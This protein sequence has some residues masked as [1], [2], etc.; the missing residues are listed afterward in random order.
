LQ[1]EQTELTCE[2]TGAQDLVPHLSRIRIFPV[3]S[4][5][6]VEVLQSR[7]LGSGALE[8]DRAWALFDESGGY[9]NGKRYTSVHRLRSKFDISA[10]ALWLRDGEGSGQ[11]FNIDRETQALENRLEGFFGFRVAIRKNTAQGFPDDEESPGPTIISVATLR[12][13]GRWF[14][15]SVEEVRNRFRANLEIDGV[16]PFWED[17]LFRDPGSSVRF[18]IGNVIFDGINP[19]QRC[20]V[21][22]RDAHSGANDDTFVR[23]FAELRERTLPVW[24]TRT[25]FNHFYRV[26]INTRLNSLAFGDEIFVGDTVEILEPPATQ[27]A[28]DAIVVR[29]SAADFWTGELEIDAVRK[30][31]PNVK[32]FRLRDPTKGALPFEFRPG[33]FLSVAVGSGSGGMRRCYSIASAPATTGYCEITVKREGVVSGILHDAMVPG[34]RVTVS[35]PMGHFMIADDEAS[36]L[37]MIAGGVG[38]TPLMSKLRHLAQRRWPGQIDLF[39]SVK[40]GNDIIFADELREIEDRLPNV[41]VHVTVTSDRSWSGRRGRLDREWIKEQVP[42]ISGRL[43]HICGPT[44][45]A[46][47]IQRLLRDLGVSDSRIVIES[48]GGPVSRDTGHTEEHEVRFVA[49]NISVMVAGG[50]TILEAALAAGLSL[51][52]GCKAGVCGRCRKT[53]LSGDVTVACDFALT[54]EQKKQGLILTCQARP[55]SPVS[56]DC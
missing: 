31:T 55:A 37:V 7:V 36:D 21:P 49:S 10:G 1:A 19:C 29:S 30:E 44:A 32:T 35:G 3:K 13:V 6:A 45:M 56:I 12:E 18:R 47:A 41:R 48:F 11:S 15:L 34:S 42:D 46:N 4:L 50:T 9:V 52:H 16:P 26:A 54:P 20:A 33:Q 24:S 40:S 8:H 51:D 23:R 5:D 17:R 22:P 2:S 28:A 25:R 14:G 43:I 39:Y 27:R 53:L 38:I